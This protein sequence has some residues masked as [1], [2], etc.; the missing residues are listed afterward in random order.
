ML[1]FRKRIAT[2]LRMSS[3]FPEWFRKTRERK[4]QTQA[5]SATVLGLT[6]PTI[7][8]WESGTDP[9]AGHLLRICKWAPIKAQRLIEL[10]AG[11]IA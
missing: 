4:H 11:K 6:S 8:R 9:R 7:S 10:L 1:R 3:P 2:V 5:E